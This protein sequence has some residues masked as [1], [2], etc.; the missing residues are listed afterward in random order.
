MF[1]IEDKVYVILSFLILLRWYKDTKYKAFLDFDASKNGTEIAN[2]IW[3]YSL[4]FYL[5]Q[6]ITSYVKWIRWWILIS[7]MISLNRFR[8]GKRLTFI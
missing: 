3:L 5:L 8:M 6:K 7:S 2:S 4:Y 1:L